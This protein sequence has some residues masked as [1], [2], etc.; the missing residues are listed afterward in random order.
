M[1]KKLLWIAVAFTLI[2]FVVLE[3]VSRFYLGLGTPPLSVAH[4]TIEYMFAP[5]QDVVRFGNRY[6][7]N[8]WG[9]RANA[10]PRRKL[11]SQEY[12][13]LVVGDSVINGG[14]L[15]DH[16]D[17]DTTILERELPSLLGRPVVVA[18][19]SAGSWGPGNWVAFFKEYGLFDADHI[20]LVVNGGDIGDTPLFDPLNPTTHP[21]RPPSC[22]SEELLTR[23]LPRYLPSWLKTPSD[24]ENPSG[25]T[26]EEL[27][28]RDL[29]VAVAEEDLVQL[30]E[31]V[32]NAGIRM[33]LVK[34]SGRPE[35]E[36]GA[37]GEG[38]KRLD[39][40]FAARRIATHSTLP[41]F[42][43]AKSDELFRDNIHPDPPGQR[44]LAD[45]ILKTVF[46]D[47]TVDEPEE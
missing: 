37:E 12:R 5:N 15:T 30:I 20:I 24:K 6:R 8:A 4:P 1:T 35:V 41:F 31:M 44:A 23:Y 43:A 38:L 2:G 13:L 45:A 21:T 46:A 34:Y 11:N 26:E 32:R 18:N 33:D 27:G 22:A 29:A 40:I 14:N 3:S 7:T 42:D 36:D 28:T 10:F 47:L 25:G 9:M 39:E 19:V 16:D 17:L